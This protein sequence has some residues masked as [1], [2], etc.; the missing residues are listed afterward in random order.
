MQCEELMKQSSTEAIHEKVARELVQSLNKELGFELIAAEGVVW[1]GIYKKESP[2]PADF[3]L[4]VGISGPSPDGTYKAIINLRYNRYF[5]TLG[6]L[7]DRMQ[8][9][10]KYLEEDR[11]LREIVTRIF[12]ENGLKVKVECDPFYSYNLLG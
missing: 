9:S 8:H 3:P 1:L 7:I 5:S 4:V 11:R 2:Y 12:T 10:S 6:Y